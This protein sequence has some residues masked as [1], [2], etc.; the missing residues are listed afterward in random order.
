MP[1]RY[2]IDTSWIPRT[3]RSDY[4]LLFIM[5]TAYVLIITAL[6]ISSHN[7]FYTNAWDLGIY[8]QALHTTAAHGKLLYYTAEL[9]GNPSG[10]LFGIHFSPLLFLLVPLYALFPSPVTLLVLRPIA[11]ALGLIPLYWIIRERLPQN[12]H[13]TFLLAAI[14]LI[15]PPVTSP[16]W[17]FDV[18]V[19]L[20]AFF[21]FALHYLDKGRFLHASIFILLALM[22]NEFVPFIIMAMALYLLLTHRHDVLAGLHRRTLTKDAVFALILLAT[23]VLWLHLAQTVITHFNPSALSTKWEWGAF[24]TSPPD[25]ALNML[26]HPIQTLTIL[27]NDGQKKFFYLV[28]LLGPLAFFSLQDPLTL[29]MALP[30]LAASLLS[31]NPN[32]YAIENQYPAF[33]SAFIFLA[34]IKGMNKLVNISQKETLQKVGVLMFTLLLLTT[35]LLP[36]GVTFLPAEPDEATRIALNTI[37]DHASA[38]VMPD[39][40]PH[41]CNALNVYPYFQKGV[42]YALINVYSWWYTVTLPRPAHTVP[43]WSDV[44]IDDD[45]GIVVNA[46][47]I[48][49]YAKGYT[50]PLTLFD[51]VA[52]TFNAHDVEIATGGITQDNV[53][54]DD[55]PLTTDVLVHQIND[56]TPLFFRIPETAFPPGTYNLTVMLKVSSPTPM[57]VITFEVTK[58]PEQAAL[59]SKTLRGTDFPHLDAWQTLTFNMTLHDPGLIEIAAYV[60]D[61]TDV[62]FYSLKMSQV[63]GSV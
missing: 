8:A 32:Y 41:R 55:V 50:G 43:A 44:D 17:G 28:S 51:G 1:L 58:K 42:D 47:G 38:S 19:F 12:Q 9:P 6:A 40:F 59:F 7:T 10:S 49:L 31:I 21:L 29:I 11:I 37:P 14:Y 24:G 61:S 30:W 34:A 60:T 33:I 57:D 27:F 13:F 39:I 18:E 46:N 5:A 36:T 4:V 25:I 15:Y 48:V 54:I 23:G 53:T 62:F 26:T 20:P 52:F 3:L 22:V 63:S 56:S 16:F 2:R 45:Y 35:L